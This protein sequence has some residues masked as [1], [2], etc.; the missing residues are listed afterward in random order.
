MEKPPIARHGKHREYASPEATAANRDLTMIADTASLSINKS[1]AKKRPHRRSGNGDDD[2][3]TPALVV[4]AR[5][6]QMSSAY[7]WQPRLA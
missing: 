3:S 7:F 6:A 4:L 1:G 2:A 5:P